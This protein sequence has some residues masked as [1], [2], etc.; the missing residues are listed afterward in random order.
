M[1]EARNKSPAD[2]EVIEVLI[3]ISRVSAR[4]ARKL[5]VLAAKRQSE[6]GGK[7]YTVK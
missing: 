2:E 1:L 6:E 7:H 5:S 4:L 3:A